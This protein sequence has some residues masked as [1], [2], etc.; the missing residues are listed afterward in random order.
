[1]DQTGGMNEKAGGVPVSNP[2]MYPGTGIW[3]KIR[4]VFSTP[5]TKEQAKK[6]IYYNILNVFSVL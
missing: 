3:R 5:T 6:M 2:S 1:M 4:T